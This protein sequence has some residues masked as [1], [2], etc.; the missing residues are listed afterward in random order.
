M[1]NNKQQQNGMNN[2]KNRN[3]FSRFINLIKRKSITDPTAGKGLKRFDFVLK[4]NAAI[5]AIVSLIFALVILTGPVFFVKELIY[6][7]N[8]TLVYDKNDKLVGKISMKRI[9]A[10]NVLNVPYDQLNQNTINALVGTEDSSFFINDG[11]DF[12]NTLQ[13][14]FKSLILKTSSGGGSTITQQIVGQTHLNKT[15]DRSVTRKI[16]EIYLS[17]FAN[18]NLTKTNIIESYLNYFPFGQDNIHGISMASQYFFDKQSYELNYPESVILVGTLN[19]PTKFNPLGGYIY[20]QYYNESQSRYKTVLIAN[21]NQ[22][23]LSKNEYNLLKQVKIKNA[24]KFNKKATENQ[25]QAFI[26]VVAKELEDIYKIDPFVKSLKVY[27]T[28]DS[29]AQKYANELTNKKHVP[30]PNNKLNNGFI[31]LKT[32]TGEIQAVGGGKQYRKRGSYLFNN[33]IDNKQQPGSA[34]KPIID[35]SPAFEFLHWGDRHVISNAPYRYPGT[36]TLVYNVDR[37][38]GGMYTIDR[39]LATSRNLVALRTMEAVYTKKGMNTLTD[40]VNALGFDIKQGEMFPSYGLGALAYGVTPMEM[41]GAYATF[42]NGGLYTQPHSIRYFTDDSGKKTVSHPVKHQV[43]DERTAFLMS[44]ALERSTK[45]PGNYLYTATYNK[46]PYAAK[47]GTSNWDEQAYKYG[48]PKMSPKDTWMVGYTSEYTTAVWA[49]YDNADIAKGYYPSF[50]DG[51][52]D[53][54]GKLWG[55]IMKFMANGK[56]TSWLAQKLPKGLIQSASGYNYTDSL[57]TRFPLRDYK[58]GL[59]MDYK[60]GF[61]Y[62][63]FDKAPYNYVAYIKSDSDSKHKSRA[64]SLKL[65]TLRNNQKVSAYY[66]IDGVKRNI[67]TKCYF[68]KELYDTCPKK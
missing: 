20:D 43:I 25:N 6:R 39:A 13:N 21:L 31:T 17:L 32:K 54:S 29:K 30:V 52:H 10:E 9:N 62:A 27:T 35:Y 67:V 11:V 2:P 41:A 57:I 50:L 64:S 26:D 33:A 56:E 48:I 55:A 34:F 15:Q 18:L 68:D 51:S 46:S 12:L 47:T 22:G 44:T 14:G 19:A 8:D 42:G 65:K 38:S 61:V 36:N 5:F 49:G 53:Y 3:F 63:T 16:R 60:T 58:V 7:P 4:A 37:Q 40:Y 45:I 28:M 66:L 59:R 24:V 23:Y 1:E